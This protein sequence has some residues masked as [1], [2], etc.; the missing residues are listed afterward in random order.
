MRTQHT[1]SYAIL[2]VVP[3]M[4]RGELI[5][6]GIILWCPKLSV[7]EAEFLLDE[8]RLKA[9]DS[10]V[11]MHEIRNHLAVIPAICRGQD[12]GGAIA[13][14]PL[15]QRFGWITATRST[16]IQTSPVHMG[17]SED[18]ALTMKQL[19]ARLVLPSITSK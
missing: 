4:D 17:Q 8:E 3:R 1:Y 9:I 12:A 19:I 14:L 2:R 7:L 11:D 15:V 18:L 6:A 13:K 5:N 16:I 10:N